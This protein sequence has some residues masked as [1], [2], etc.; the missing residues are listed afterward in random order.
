MQNNWL[1][2]N[3]KLNSPSTDLFRDALH[4]ILCQTFFEACLDSFLDLY[5]STFRGGFHW[6]R[7][8][9]KLDSREQYK[10]IGRPPKREA[11][12]AKRS[13][14]IRI[15]KKRRQNKRDDY[16]SDARRNVGECRAKT[17]KIRRRK[18]FWSWSK[19]EVSE[20]RSV[21]RTA[22]GQSRLFT[23]VLKQG[24]CNNELYFIHYICIRTRKNARTVYTRFQW[25][26][27]LH[28]STA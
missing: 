13:R 28:I 26:I 23:T 27:T 2:E 4:F 10:S 24:N 11:I 14:E 12:I 6:R 17:H 19:V 5:K 9:I 21:C 7:L 15:W 3:W 1:L 22:N 8:N 25:A 20:K 16:Y 18:A